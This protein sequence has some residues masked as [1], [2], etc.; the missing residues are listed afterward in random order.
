MLLSLICTSH[1][2]HQTCGLSW[3][4]KGSQPQTWQFKRAMFA[5]FVSPQHGHSKKWRLKMVMFAILHV[6]VQAKIYP[7]SHFLTGLK[8]GLN[9]CLRVNSSY[10]LL[11]VHYLGHAKHAAHPGTARA[12]SR[13]YGR[14]TM[15]ILALYL[16]ITA[17]NLSV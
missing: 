11:C 6:Q 1:G 4:H 17:K 9:R 10:F 12:V 7:L 2:P 5:V 8:D 13:H 16:C 3:H 14:F 15:A